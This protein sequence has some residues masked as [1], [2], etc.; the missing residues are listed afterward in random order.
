M[1]IFVDTNIF[2]AP[3]KRR[4]EVAAHKELLSGL[5]GLAP[6][7]LVT[8]TVRD[9]FE[10]NRVQAYQTANAAIPSGLQIPDIW[11]HHTDDAAQSDAIIKS[12]K[13]LSN[14][15]RKMIKDWTAHHEKNLR[16][17]AMGVD[18]V[19]R[20]LA[21]VFKRAMSE[22]AE[23]LQ[24]ARVRKEKGQ[25]PG[26]RPNA[27][28]DQISWEQIL[29]S[30]KGKGAVWIVSEDGDYFDKIDGELLLKPTL[31]RELLNVDALINI[32][33]FPGLVD[34]FK[35]AQEAGLIDQSKLPTAAAMQAVTEELNEERRQPIF[36][37]PSS[38]WP[39]PPCPASPDGQHDFRDLVPLRSQHGGLTYQGYCSRCGA[40]VD[41]AEPWE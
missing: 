1:L 39:T 19:S 27:L 21:P 40:F 28:G 20:I 29:D 13:K 25:P 37:R 17:I 6:H 4:R 34:M 24:R 12:K 35:A 10:R 14:E 5:S 41:T 23:Q 7:L 18:D 8:D 36:F 31:R 38:L 26:K 30:A 33:C 9:E 32:R 16:S 2:L 15:C 3:Y 11:L 22:S